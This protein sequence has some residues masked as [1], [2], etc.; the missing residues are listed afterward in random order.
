MYLALLFR[1]CKSQGALMISISKITVHCLQFF[2][3]L[4]I[5]RV[6]EPSLGHD[7]P[8]LVSAI[9]DNATLE[10]PS[11]EGATPRRHT[12]PLTS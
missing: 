12:I 10:S 11:H 1:S 5:L 4:N 3:S 2:G 6:N 7:F 8:G 9:N